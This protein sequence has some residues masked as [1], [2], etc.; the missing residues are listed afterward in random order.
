MSDLVLSLTGPGKSWRMWQRVGE[1]DCAQ[2]WR[3]IRAAG[4]ADALLFLHRAKAIEVVIVWLA[5]ISTL[6]LSGLSPR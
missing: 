1:D 5:M 4:I 3:A 2:A 6:I